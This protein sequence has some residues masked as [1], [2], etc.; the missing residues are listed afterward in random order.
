MTQKESGFTLIE[1]LVTLA[2]LVILVTFAIPSF[3]GMIASN[4]LLGAR[5]NLLSAL[6][7]AKGEAVGQ[8]RP[9]SICPSTDGATCGS[10]G[11]W[12]SG[13]IVVQDN[14]ETGS[15][16]VASVLR[17]FEGPNSAQVTVTESD[18]NDYIRY[19]PTGMASGSVSNPAMLNSADEFGFCDPDADAA[20]Y[21]LIVSIS[22]GQVITGSE[23]EANCP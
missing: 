2:I 19:L 7:Y 14:N 22:T 18:G 3:Q 23:A 10:S 9:V 15:V 8:N 16:S 12:P 11:D 13:W 17:Q 5:D 1:L 6:Q 21:S 4:Q 20:P